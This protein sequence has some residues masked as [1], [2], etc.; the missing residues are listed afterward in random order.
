LGGCDSFSSL[1]SAPLGKEIPEFSS[2]S[3]DAVSQVDDPDPTAAW[4]LDSPTPVMSS[5]AAGVVLPQAG[6]AGLGLQ[7]PAKALQAMRASL[8]V[9]AMKD[10]NL[11]LCKEATSVVSLVRGKRTKVV[12]TETIRA[13]SASLARVRKS[14]RLR[15]SAA[16]TP[17]LEKAK[18]LAA[19]R[20]LDSMTGTDFSVLDVLPDSHLSSVLSDSCIVFTPSAGSPVEALSILRAREKVQAALAAAALR[21]DMELAASAAREAASSAQGEEGTSAP[22]TCF[23]DVPT[24]REMGVDQELGGGSAAAGEAACGAPPSDACPPKRG[25]GRPRGSTAKKAALAVR[26]GKKGSS[27]AR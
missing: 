5:P 27:S 16:S 26:K 19:E 10:R 9:E 22:D 3:T 8:E 21:K 1:L 13:A 6:S 17:S 15:G 11:D 4:L 12:T 18:R 7:Q 24:V 23:A 20:N 2:L 14:S 25:R